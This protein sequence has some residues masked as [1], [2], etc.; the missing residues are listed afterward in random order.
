[1]AQL[2]SLV[3][4]MNGVRVG[5]WTQTRGA[6]LLQYDPSWVESPA[7][8]ALSLSLPFTPA[9]VAHRGSVVVNFFDNLL[10]DADAIRSRIRSQFA[11]RST[12]TFDLLAA[13]GRECVGAI[14]L[15]P[16]GRAPVGFDRI[17]G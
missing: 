2:S 13:V 11:T 17:E 1:M 10:P 6:H 8:R 9:N 12:E 14:Q 15:L 5:V 7:G 4:W 16:E 3:I